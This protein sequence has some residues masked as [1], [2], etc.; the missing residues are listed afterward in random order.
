L[1][2]NIL[3]SRKIPRTLVGREA[4]EALES[5]QLP[6]FTVEICQRI[7]YIEAMLAGISVL[8]H[9]PR[10]AAANEIQQLRKEVLKLKRR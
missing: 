6:I 9:A 4:R 5:Y 2:S 10:S 3:I 7:A 1:A 8:K